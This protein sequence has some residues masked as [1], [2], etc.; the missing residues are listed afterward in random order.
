VEAVN[1][2]GPVKEELAY[3]LR[4]AF[5]DRSLRI[6]GDAAIR[7]DLR[8]VKKETTAAGNIRFSADRGKNGHSDRFWALALALH[9]SAQAT[10]AG[11]IYV[12]N[13]ART[14]AVRERRTRREV[15]A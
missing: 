2:T 6:P 11:P 10:D 7:A 3:P 12:F 13:T 15:A 9:A 8:A 5:E 1:F 4:A 14:R